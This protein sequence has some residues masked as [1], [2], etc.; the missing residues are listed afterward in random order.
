MKKKVRAVIAIVF[1]LISFPLLAFA[2]SLFGIVPFMGF[3]VALTYPIHWLGDN[4]EGM[5]DALEGLEML[6][7]PVV[8]PCFIWYKYYLT[9]KLVLG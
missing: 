2:I 7:A 4:E 3:F 9:G 6:I 8:Y 5:S 1:G